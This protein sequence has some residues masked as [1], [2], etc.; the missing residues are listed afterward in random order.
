MKFSI[1]IPTYNEQDDIINTLNAISSQTYKNFEV[2]VVD[3]SNDNTYEI[4]KNFKKIPI[5]LIKPKKRYGRSEARNIGLKNSTGNVCIIL[6]ADVIL[7]KSFIEKVKVHYDQGYQAVTVY[8]EVENLNNKYARYVGLH[9]FWKIKRNVYKKRQEHLNNLWWCEGF[10]VKRSLAMKTSLFPSGFSMPIV[11]GEDVAF[12]NDLRKLNCRAFFDEKIIVK[13]KAPDTFLEFWHTRVGRGE[14]T[15]QIRSFV[16]KWSLKKI[17]IIITLKSL[18]RLTKFL[19]IFPMLI[20]SIR[21]AQFSNE[22][23]YISE[24]LILAKLWFLEQLA[25]SFGEFKCLINLTF[26]RRKNDQ[27]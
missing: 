6:N 4:I 26:V 8:T 15:P 20:Y 27:S 7:P 19:T 22:K 13:H 25:F 11:A 1:I 5:N 2:I 12:V 10:S 21:L 24:I 14:G 9:H 18:I 16:D 17:F 23:Y 3:D